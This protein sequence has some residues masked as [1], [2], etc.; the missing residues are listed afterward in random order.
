MLLGH[1][2]ISITSRIYTH[3]LDGDLK[4]QDDFRFG[5]D[6]NKNSVDRTLHFP[7]N[8]GSDGTRTTTFAVTGNFAKF[9]QL[10]K[11]I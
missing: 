11:I 9:H 10:M 2:D 6:K 8:G 3:L 5:F 4:V 7:Q 1:A